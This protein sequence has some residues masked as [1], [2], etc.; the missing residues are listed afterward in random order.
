MNVDK[1]SMLYIECIEDKK[2]FVQYDINNRSIDV[3]TDYVFV[4]IRKYSIWS[5][6]YLFLENA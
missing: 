6:K 2:I 5:P 1:T 3:T 4:V